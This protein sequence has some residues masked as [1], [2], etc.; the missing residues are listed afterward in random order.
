[1][2]FMLEMSEKTTKH[3]NCSHHQN[4]SDIF[5]SSKG[6]FVSVPTVVFLEVDKHMETWIKNLQKGEFQK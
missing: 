4:V 6:N 5:V 1:M 2:F 3:V